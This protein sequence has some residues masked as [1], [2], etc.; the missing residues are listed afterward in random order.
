MLL[1]APLQTL[2]SEV[3]RVSTNL[4]LVFEQISYKPQTMAE[5]SNKFIALDKPIKKYI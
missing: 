4:L 2:F 5:N 3:C 1:L